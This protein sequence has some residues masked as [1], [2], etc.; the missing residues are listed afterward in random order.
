[1]DGL[2]VLNSWVVGGGREVVLV[3]GGELVVVGVGGGCVV[4]VV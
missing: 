4:V 3:V 2:V 1:M